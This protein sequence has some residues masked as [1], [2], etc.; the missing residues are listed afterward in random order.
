MWQLKSA[1][2]IQLARHIA[3]NDEI[4]A[5]NWQGLSVGN[6]HE[7]DDDGVALVHDLFSS[8]FLFLDGD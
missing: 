6:C 3:N 8:G 1:S 7:I 2:S 4:M 5:E